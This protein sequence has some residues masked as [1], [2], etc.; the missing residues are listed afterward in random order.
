MRRVSACRAGVSWRK[1]II[2]MGAGA[3]AWGRGKPSC[4]LAGIL[5]AR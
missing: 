4:G 1:R 3:A 2:I 5:F